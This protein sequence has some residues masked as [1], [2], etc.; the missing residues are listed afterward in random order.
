MC[1]K[2][3]QQQVCECKMAPKKGWAKAYVILKEEPKIT[4]ALQNTDF[5]AI[6]CTHLHYILRLHLASAIYKSKP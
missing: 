3:I 4:V 6:N 1:Q 5:M 2:D